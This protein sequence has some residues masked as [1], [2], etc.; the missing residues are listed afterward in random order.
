MPAGRR[1]QRRSRARPTCS[2]RRRAGTTRS[3]PR[4]AQQ[5]RRPGHARRPCRRRC[6]ASLPDFARYHR[7]KAALLGHGDRRRCRGGTCSPRSAPRRRFDVGRGH[8]RRRATRSA[9]TR[10]AWPASPSRAVDDGWIDAEPRAGKVGGAFCMP[11]RDEVSRVLLNFDGSFDSV[12]TLAHELGHAYHN[13]NLGQPHAAAAP[14]A[15][16]R[17]PRRRHLLR[18]DHGRGRPGRRPAT[19]TARGWRSSTATWP[20]SAQVVVDIHSRFLFERAL[21]AERER[22]VLSAERLQRADARGAARGLRR[23]RSTPTTC[24]PYMWAVKG[25]YYTAV[26]QLALHLR[27]AVRHRACTP[28]SSATPTASAAATTT[29]SAPP[30]WATPPSSPPASASTSATRPSGPPASTSSAARIDDFVPAGRRLT[31][32]A[33]LRAESVVR[34]TI[35]TQMVQCRASMTGAR[36]SRV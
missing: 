11:V 9:P 12:Q 20:G 14:D 29:C 15:R 8:R 4:P 27:A 25:H 30:G 23:R 32:S 10:P 31:T 34:Q 36:V 6:V 28:S 3:T 26:L 33:F 19:T 7:A 16:W 21:S 5:Q 24:H 1:A 17:W 22:G 13:T 18:D 35:R 2:N